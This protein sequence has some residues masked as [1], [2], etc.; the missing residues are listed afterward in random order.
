MIDRRN[1]PI[2]MDFGL[3]RQTDDQ[4]DAKLTRDGTI[5]GS[6]SYMSPEQVQCGKLG[7]ATDIYSLGV[8]LFQLVIGRLPFEESDD[9]DL[10]RA[11]IMEKLSSPELKSQGFSPHLHYFI[12]KMMAKEID[13]RYQGFEQLILDVKEQ[14]AGYE[15]L[16]FSRP[17]PNR[18]VRRPRKQ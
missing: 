2:V 11:H 13:V 12:E 10:L 18:P 14:L 5:L 15:S 6:P 1:E 7:S 4:V 16:D 17:S 3:A 9:Q 8:T